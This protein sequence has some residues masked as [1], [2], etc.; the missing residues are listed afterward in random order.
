MKQPTEPQQVVGK[1]DQQIQQ[2]QAGIM[3]APQRTNGP[4]MGTTW[5]LLNKPAYTH[6]KDQPLWEYKGLHIGE[7]HKMRHLDLHHTHHKGPIQN[8]LTGRT[9]PE[10]TIERDDSGSPIPVDMSVYTVRGKHN[11]KLKS[12]KKPRRM[13]P[14]K[15]I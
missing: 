4:Y 14:F 2:E 15:G 3:T 10:G 6:N 9:S 1:E 11:L 13:L 8:I 5:E 7:H 12:N